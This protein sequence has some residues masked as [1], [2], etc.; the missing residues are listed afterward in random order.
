MVT[1]L[2]ACGS[3]DDDE[4]QK[5]TAAILELAPVGSPFM[6]VPASMRELGFDCVAERRDVSD[7]HGVVRGTQSHFSCTREERVWLVCSHRVRAVFMHAGDKV[8]NVLVNVGRF[9]T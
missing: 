6:D 5:E 9:C 3:A 8:A 1:L 4:I 2:C 7:A